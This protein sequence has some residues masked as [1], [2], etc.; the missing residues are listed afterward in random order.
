M[1]CSYRCL[2]K[3][4]VDNH[5][6]IQKVDV[7]VLKLSRFVVYSPGIRLYECLVTCISLCVYIHVTYLYS[8]PPKYSPPPPTSGHPSHA[9]RFSRRGW[10]SLYIYPS[11][12]ATPSN[13]A[14]GHPFVVPISILTPSP[15]TNIIFWKPGE[16][17]VSNF[18]FEHIC[19]IQLPN[20]R[21]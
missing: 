13:A 18:N 3:W 19:S 12:T 5:K 21:T 16:S 7:Y 20:E 8:D 2:V 10:F 14:N 9:A 1:N 17:N 15:T 11:P 4:R 6:A